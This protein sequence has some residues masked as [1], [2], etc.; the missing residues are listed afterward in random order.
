MNQLINK[1]M[2]HIDVNKINRSSCATA[3]VFIG[4]DEMQHVFVDFAYVVEPDGAINDADCIFEAPVTDT[5]IKIANEILAKIKE[6][7]DIEV[8]PIVD[9]EYSFDEKE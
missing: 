5:N 1:A 4:D 8:F 9:G 6:K 7:Y 2:K 3:Q